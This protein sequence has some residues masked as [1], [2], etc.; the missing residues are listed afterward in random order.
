MLETGSLIK[1][2]LI[3]ILVIFVLYIL[4]SGYIKASPNEVII[5][6]GFRKP[7]FLVGRAGIRIP[8][9]EKV[10]RLS[11]EMV[12]VDVK[13]QNDVQTKDFI[14]VKVDGNAQIKI[15]SS[16]EIIGK[17]A[18]N[19]LNKSTD[20]IAEEVVD[21]LEGQMREIVGRMQLK[22]F[23]GDNQVFNEAVAENAIPE[24]ARMGIELISFQ[25]QNYS[26]SEGIIKD[27]GAENTA[28]IKS[29]ASINRIEAEKR[30]S[31][32]QSQAAEESNARKAEAE[33]KMA[34][35]NHKVAM[36]RAQL[37]EE[38][39]I[40]NAKAKLAE[41]IE[42]EKQRKDLE[43]ST[44]EAN[45]EKSERDIEIQRNKL[46]AD[47]NN[48]AD[49]RLYEEEKAAEGIRKK[50]EAE[51][52]GIRL[53]AQAEA[54]GIREKAEA[55]KAYNDA[56]VLKMYMDTLVSM[57]ENIARPL[58]KVDAMTFYGEGSS[59]QYIKDQTKML[60]QLNKGLQDSVGLDIKTLASSFMGAKIASKE[61]EDHEKD[62]K[63][64]SS[65]V[66]VPEKQ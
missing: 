40:A 17:A 64:D 3:A 46:K 5:V 37:L 52:E 49:A 65:K 14:N 28:R 47:K 2:G 38:E 53:K 15:S 6:T 55:M 16:P 45:K 19:F 32:A 48:E 20:E 56:A 21:V 26:N 8:F 43:I 25:I 57:S 23:I 9:L 58:E 54:D 36:R 7:R 44:A 27:L 61:N 60:D 10:D 41:K 35:Q 30:E 59:T 34:E 33:E 1:V 31:L 24:L 51:A 63:E 42:E 39:G 11:L 4:F 50:Y 12:K 66:V 62:K 22:E 18:E 13:T 29:E